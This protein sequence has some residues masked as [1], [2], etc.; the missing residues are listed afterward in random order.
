MMST[1]ERKLKE[2][3]NRKQQI[4]DVAEAIMLETGLN[5]LS[6][7]LIAQYM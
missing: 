7:D 3:Q 1:Q 5:G 4:L 6:S 2:K